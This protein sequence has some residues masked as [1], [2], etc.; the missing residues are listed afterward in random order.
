[1]SLPRLIIAGVALLASGTAIT[2]VGGVVGIYPQQITSELDPVSAGCISCHDG[3]EG[4]NVRYC[5]IS[6][7]NKGCGGHIVSADYA[8]LAAKDKNL[9]PPGSLS[10]ELTLYEGKITCVTCHGDDPHNVPLAIDNT[11]SALCRVC[12]L[13]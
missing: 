3:S 8:A 4:L 13:K 9:R 5:L 2:A 12:H 6:Q 1:M 11:G 10:A 7:K